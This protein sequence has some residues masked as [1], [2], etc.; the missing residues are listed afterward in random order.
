MDWL[1]PLLTVALCARARSTDT[2]ATSAATRNARVNGWRRGVASGIGVLLVD[3]RCGRHQAGSERARCL[4]DE[5]LS[6]WHRRADANRVS[7]GGPGEAAG[8]A[9]RRGARVHPPAGAA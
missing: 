6:H 9:A 3:P 7:I 5:R 4:G 1:L 8:R 2:A